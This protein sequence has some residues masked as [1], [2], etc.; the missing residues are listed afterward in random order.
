MSK[1][2]NLRIADW[3]KF[4]Q[5]VGCQFDH[6]KSGHEVW[7]RG[8]LTRPVVFQTHVEPVP[9]FV[10]RNSLRTLGLNRKQP[11]KIFLDL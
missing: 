9:E 2:S 11:E 10:I 5:A 8:D 1:L 4:L 3:K 6:I 7:H